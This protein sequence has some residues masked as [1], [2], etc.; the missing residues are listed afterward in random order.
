MTSCAWL[1]RN[2][3]EVSELAEPAL[4]RQLLAAATSR[5]TERAPRPT[6]VRRNRAVLLNALDYAVELKLLDQNP[7]K[8]LKWRAPRTSSEVDRRV[9]RQSHSGQ[10]AARSRPGAAD[11]AGRGWSHSSASSTT[12]GCVPRKLSASA[13]QDVKLPAL[14]WDEESAQWREPDDAWGEIHLR[15]ARP[16]VGNQWTDDGSDRDTPRPQAPSRGRKPTGSLPTRSHQ[17]AS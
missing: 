10:G 2:T 17:A 12:A 1:A 15:S 7:I 16:D 3:R 4:C 14:A 13:A 8:N 5:W 11:P 6:S 9:R